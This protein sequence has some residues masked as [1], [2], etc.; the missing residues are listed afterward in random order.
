MSIV[1]LVATARDDGRTASCPLT[2]KPIKPG[3]SAA[4]LLHFCG[5]PLEALGLSRFVTNLG[6]SELGYEIVSPSLG[7]DIMYH[8]DAKSKVAPTCSAILY[9]TILN[10]TQLYCTILKYA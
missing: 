7:F 9:S 6:R 2:R 5:T 8:P 10:D 4:Q 3:T 1:Q